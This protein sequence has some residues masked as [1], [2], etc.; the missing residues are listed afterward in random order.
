M[1]LICRSFVC[2]ILTA[3]LILPVCASG[4][5]SVAESL[6]MTGAAV[7]EIPPTVSAEAAVLTDEKG[8][9]LWSRNAD[10]RMSPASTTKIMTALTALA[11]CADVGASV[12]IPGE[13]VGIEGSSVYLYEG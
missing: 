5:D 6:L 12:R 4:G 7:T 9:I 2:L 8:N 1:K 13:A 11:D 10:K 3:L